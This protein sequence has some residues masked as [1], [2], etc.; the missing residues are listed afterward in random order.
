MN[1]EKKDR[2]CERTQLMLQDALIALMEERSYDSLT[3]EDIT[4]RANIGR[5]TF[6]L[7]YQ[8]KDDLLIEIMR[9]KISGFSFGMRS[10]MDWLNDKPTH[11]LIEFFQVFKQRMESVQGM[12]LQGRDM[13]IIQKLNQVISQQMEENLRRSFPATEFDIPL[14]LLAHAMA[15]SHIWLAEW[16]TAKREPYS[17]EQIATTSHRMMRAMLKDA[18]K[19]YDSK[20]PV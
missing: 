17:A 3:I 16:W 18:M 14:P 11:E 20:Q 13:S 9:K 8:S 5:T 12:V 1:A 19:N 10:A 2:R 15:G 6:Y 7:H 4:E